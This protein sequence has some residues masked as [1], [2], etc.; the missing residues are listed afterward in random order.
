[1]TIL[2]PEDA[3]DPTLPEDLRAEIRAHFARR[4]N[5]SPPAAPPPRPVEP[6]GVSK[7]R[8]IDLLLDELE[9]LGTKRAKAESD[10][11]AISRRQ[12]EIARA[13]TPLVDGLT[14]GARSPRL[15]RL[16]ACAADGAAGR[17]PKGQSRIAREMLRFLA[18]QPAEEIS[19]AQITVHLRRLGFEVSDN[20]ASSM[21][22]VWLKDGVVSRTGRGLYQANATHADLAHLI[23]EDAEEEDTSP[24]D[25]AAANR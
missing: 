7:I 4:F 10:M 22:H 6:D 8:M 18:C 13:L 9:R 21:L 11:A 3:D 12:G 23:D 16:Q 5:L 20:Y 19:P 1:M 24:A 25:Q 2:K 14:E 15:R 17:R